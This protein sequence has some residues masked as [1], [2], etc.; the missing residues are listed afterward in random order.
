MPYDD[1]ILLCRGSGEQHVPGKQKKLSSICV[2]MS[3]WIECNAMQ[4]K[5]HLGSRTNDGIYGRGCYQH[6]IV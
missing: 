3:R 1:G 2:C 6:A 5:Q 4:C